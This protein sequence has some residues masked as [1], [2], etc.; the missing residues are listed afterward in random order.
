MLQK[1]IVLLTL[2]GPFHTCCSSGKVDLQD[3]SRWHM[4]Q[5]VDA[6]LP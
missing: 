2:L 5:H 1:L 3:K 4:G 6:N